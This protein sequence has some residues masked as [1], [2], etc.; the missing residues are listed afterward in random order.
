MR[1]SRSKVR[2]VQQSR[3]AEPSLNDMMDEDVDMDYTVTG[4]HAWAGSVKNDSLAHEQDNM[5]SSTTVPGMGYGN[6]HHHHF[7]NHK[8]DA[9]GYTVHEDCAFAAVSQ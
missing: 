4:A 9:E 3:F 2:E 7:A 6:V 1:N 5:S 8:N